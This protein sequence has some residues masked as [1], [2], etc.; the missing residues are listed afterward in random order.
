MKSDKKTYTYRTIDQIRRL[1]ADRWNKLAV[2]LT[3][4]VFAL[5]AA[6]MGIR[7]SRSSSSVGLGLSI[8]VIFLY[9]ILGRY[10]YTLAAQG[11]LAPMVGAFAPL[12]LG[13]V[14]AVILLKRAA[15]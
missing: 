11:T 8:L 9:W 10:T 2:P 14:A 15:K 7:P 5:L 12:A 3:S 4:L 13:I 6:P 1:D